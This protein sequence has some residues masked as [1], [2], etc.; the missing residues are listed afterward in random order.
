MVKISVVTPS[1]NQGDYISDSI[2][3]VISQDYS[4]LEHIIIDNESTD[5]TLEVLNYYK[6][7]YDHIRYISEPDN[8]QSEALNK[9]FKISNGDWILWLNADDLL[10]DGAINKFL[11]YI[12]SN[13]DSDVLYGH[14]N[15]VNKKLELIR[16]IYHIDFDYNLTLFRIHL[17][18]SSGTFFRSA[19]LKKN[20]LNDQFHYMMD[21]EWY[22]RCGKEYNIKLIDHILTDFR[23]TDDNK[24]GEQIKSGVLNDQ[25]RLEI[26]YSYKNYLYPSFNLDNQN[27]RIKILK[28]AYIIKYYF[29]KSKYLKKYLSQKYFN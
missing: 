11:N 24:T 22:M 25:Q 20:L 4:N 13:P 3:S 6:N 23:V 12:N 26:A 5:K 18:P 10:K 2:E 27:Y 16:T 1:F 29:L 8:G 15:L 17:P 21:T 28:K 19:I 14:V 7:N 9:G